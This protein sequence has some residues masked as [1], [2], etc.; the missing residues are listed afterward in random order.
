RLDMRCS[1]KVGSEPVDLNQV[2][3]TITDGT[4]T[5]DLRYIEGSLV[6]AKAITGASSGIYTSSA[7]GAG[8]TNT[9]YRL[10][11]DGD[12][13]TTHTN[14]ADGHTAVMDI[15]KRVYSDAH[16]DSDYNGTGLSAIDYTLENSNGTA[17]IWSD[18]ASSTTGTSGEVLAVDA[19]V[20]TNNTTAASDSY[21]KISS[22][23]QDEYFARA[24]KFYVVEEIRDEDKSYTSDNPVMNTGDLVKMVVLTGP[25]NIVTGEGDD[26][27]QGATKDGSD[28]KFQ[29]NNPLVGEANLDLDPRSTVTISMIP[30]GG[31]GTTVDFVTPSS[32]GT[33]V[34]VDLYP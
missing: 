2:V 7:S 31:A 23:L 4:M 28:S 17:V 12:T 9:T 16:V 1:L 20:F 24:D 29:Y 32:F 13:T 15:F 21:G 27:L 19:G 30:E 10:L 34:S 3:I 11:V 26:W 25:S 33:H 14:G 22:T 18:A 6:A 8:L 5:N